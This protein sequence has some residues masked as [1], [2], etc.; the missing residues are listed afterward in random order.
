[1]VDKLPFGRKKWNGEYLQRPE[2]SARSGELQGRREPG[3]RHTVRP[4]LVWPTLRHARLAVKLRC[5][6]LGWSHR[7]RCC[8]QG[9]SWGRKTRQPGSG[10]QAALGSRSLFHK[11]E[12]RPLPKQLTQRPV[13]EGRISHL[14]HLTS[15]SPEQVPLPPM[16]VSPRKREEAQS[17]GALL[18]VE[19]PDA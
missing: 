4:N 3:D 16:I 9:A 19:W 6:V 17:P 1:M 11:P 18:A 15:Y 7:G 14:V 5:A 8:C 13:R 12:L 10:W 2:A